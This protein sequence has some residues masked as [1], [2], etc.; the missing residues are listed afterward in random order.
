[1]AS[2]AEHPPADLWRARLF[3]AAPLLF[4]SLAFAAGAVT[5]LSIA[6]PALPHVRG[7]DALERLA[8]ELPELTASIAGVALMGLAT[9]LNRRVDAAW[10]VT[11][12]LLSA[13]CLYAFFRHGHL[14]AAGAAGATALLL[15]LSRRA[16]YRHSRLADLVPDRRVALGIAFAFGIAFVGALLWV[17]AR[18]A[19]AE[20]PW[21]ALL[22]DPHLGRPGRALAIGLAA[23][24]VVVLQHYLLSRHR[25]APALAA[26]ED[27]ARAE[28]MIEVADDALPDAELA[29]TRDKSF[30]FV[31]GAFVMNARGGASLIAM[32]P[33]VGKRAA[34]KSALSALRAEAERLSLRPV[35]YAAPPDLLPDL[36]D[37][38]FR[39]E[40]V[41]ENA[42]VD[43]AGFTIA[44]S[45]RQKIRAARRRFVEREGAVFEMLAPPH[46]Q[47][48]WDELRPVSDAWLAAHGGREKAFSLGAF[49]PD[50]LAR[51]HI[52]TARIHG[53][54]IAFANIW[55]NAKKTR[56]A[57]DLMR[58]V[59]DA[60]PNGLMD[61]LFTE[62]L[63]WAQSQH[64][65]TFDL[66]MAPLAGLASEKYAS[67]FARIG[68]L[69]HERGEQ[70]YG[71][72]GLRAFKGKFG[73]RWEPRYIAAP[74]TWTMPIVLAEVAML[75]NGPR[76]TAAAE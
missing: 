73:P 37:V 64:M 61:F 2:A 57:I 49:N 21:W 54:V 26:S 20:A 1:M 55:L 59:P 17:G 14:A 53:R 50:Y 51:A 39:V 18:P 19:W 30:L 65:T 45:A 62:I 8:D 69:V 34:W 74:G 48:L 68:R 13:V 10:A 41:G 67:L 40:K 66:G 4:S 7:L 36:L 32:G 29:F 6:T 31:D 42:I 72:Q 75:T 56:G 27:F 16:F 70:F 58:F 76:H 44:G 43:L 71:F 12:A 46:A 38:G 52:A 22:T 60:A 33:P 9:G 3:E 35:V 28:A 5:L 25:G 11:T 24:V 47:A 63:L 15:A 23:C